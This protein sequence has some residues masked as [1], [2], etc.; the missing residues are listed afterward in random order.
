[1]RSAF[2]TTLALLMSLPTALLA[3]EMQPTEQL[4]QRYR[5]SWDL[6]FWSVSKSHPIPGVY[7][8]EMST[9]RTSVAIIIGVL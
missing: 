3:L 8:T 1:M 7:S 4:A 6:F 5:Q 2:T 9:N